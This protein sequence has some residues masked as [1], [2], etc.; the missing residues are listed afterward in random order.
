ELPD[1]YKGISPLV[2]VGG[3][4][5]YPHEN[6]GFILNQI[7]LTDKDTKENVAKKQRIV[8]VIIDN[9]QVHPKNE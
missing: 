8:K 9:I 3:L 1:W 2:N 5:R 6:G 4:V 7:K